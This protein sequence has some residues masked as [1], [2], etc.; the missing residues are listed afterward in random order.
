MLF[1]NLVKIGFFKKSISDAD[2]N[3]D[4]D[5]TTDKPDNF[6]INLQYKNAFFVLLS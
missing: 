3:N 5:L 6:K 1:K 2:Y 4:D